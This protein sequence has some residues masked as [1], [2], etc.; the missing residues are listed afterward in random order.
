[1][2][3]A[4]KQVT[5]LWEAIVHP[6]QRH[7]NDRSTLADLN[8]NRHHHQLPE[9]LTLQWLGT[10]GFSL[11][12]E[13]FTLLIDPYFS[14]PSLKR[15]LSQHYLQPDRQ[16]IDQRVQ[17]A[18]AVVVG[19][20]HFDH[21]LDVPDIVRAF[22]AHVYGSQS[23]YQLMELHQLQ[24]K[25]TK[26]DCNKVYEM[27]PFEVTFIESVH[28]KLLLGMK[29]PYEG[30]IC[31]EHLDCL[32]GGHYRCGQVFG[33]HIKVAGVTFYHQGSANLIDD[34]IRH[35]DVDYFLCGISGRGFTRNYTQRILTK[36]TPKVVIPHH[37]DNFFHSFDA[38][39]S[40]I[41]NVNLGGFVEEVERVSK[42]FEI[43]TLDLL[44][45]I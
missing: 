44:Q 16:S 4:Q 17:S 34:N 31:C 10:A 37:F 11:E 13:G 26:V 1:M 35:H 23:L 19:H 8:W 7:Q 27:G 24:H 41:L 39:M 32:S 3:L 38:P 20:T 36:L 14:R 33:I 5:G 28:S 12:Y 2:T 21:A 22:D 45:K 18:D 29:V 15:V 9:G 25:A 30:E 40:F 6:E 43:T 42:E